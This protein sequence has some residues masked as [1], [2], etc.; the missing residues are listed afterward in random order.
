MLEKARKRKVQEYREAEGIK[1][2]KEKR[3]WGAMI[4]RRKEE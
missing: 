3:E 2:E 1:Q 4:I